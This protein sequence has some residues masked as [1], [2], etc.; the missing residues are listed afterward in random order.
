MKDCLYRIFLTIIICALV[1]LNHTSCV[2]PD[3]FTDASEHPVEESGRFPDYVYDEEM[4]Q[5][6]SNK[7]AYAAEQGYYYAVNHLLYFYDTESEQP[8]LLCTKVSCSHSDENCSA[9][10]ETEI[11]SSNSRIM[12]QGGYLYLFSM[13]DNYDIWVDRYDPDYTEKKRLFCLTKSTDSPRTLLG[14]IYGTYVRDGWLYYTTF[15]QDEEKYKN[16]DYST[17]VSF[18]RIR[19][20]KNAE[21]ETLYSYESTSGYGRIMASNKD[22]FCI[23]I[24][25]PR[26]NVDKANYQQCVIRYNESDG[27]EMIWEYAGSERKNLLGAEG[28]GPE[29][30][31]SSIM[32]RDGKLIYLT[33]RKVGKGFEGKE[34]MPEFQGVGLPSDCT[35]VGEIDL[36]TG[37]SKVIYETPYWWITRLSTDGKYYYILE[38]GCYDMFLTALDTEGN[39]IR[40]YHIENTEAFA[41]MMDEEI[42]RNDGAMCNNRGDIYIMLTDAR[43]LMLRIKESNDYKDLHGNR[44]LKPLE[45]PPSIT[46][47]VG[48]IST[49]DF[50]SGKEVKIRQI[51]ALN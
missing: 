19:L 14:D 27:A 40:R 42:E 5:L 29:S 15:L 22:I 31:N 23:T 43:Y 36:Y 51:F 50:L 48:V 35:V 24:G 16:Q 6:V 2:R 30:I 4:A 17:T 12:K 9:Y 1:S 34:N 21:P 25:N 3:N 32:N 20:Q 39:V 41:A 46:T 8:I 49:E 18:N 45:D 47:A 33:N 13:D 28:E 10:V 38:Q 44:E 37:E 11:N 26:G 7:G